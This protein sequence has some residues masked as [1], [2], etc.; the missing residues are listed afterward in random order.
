M[1]FY[2]LDCPKVVGMQKGQYKTA[3]YELITI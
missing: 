2:A 3:L 1:P